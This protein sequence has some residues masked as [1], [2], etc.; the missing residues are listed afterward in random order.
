MNEFQL[1]PRGSRWELTDNG[2]PV[3][4][5]AT[6]QK[7]LERSFAILSEITGTLKIYKSD[8]SIEQERTFPLNAN[9]AEILV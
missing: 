8:G 5:F 9:A 1:R 7:A 3:G 4:S 6:K 2:N